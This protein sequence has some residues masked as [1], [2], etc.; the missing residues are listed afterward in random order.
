MSPNTADEKICVYSA[1]ELQQNRVHQG[2]FLDPS[3]IPSITG[4]PLVKSIASCFAA[5]CPG[6]WGVQLIRPERKPTRPTVN[7]SCS[8]CLNTWRDED[9]S[10]REFLPGTRGKADGWMV[11]NIQ[12]KGTFGGYF[13]DVTIIKDREHGRL[14]TV[15]GR[16]SERGLIMV[17]EPQSG[18]NW[19]FMWNFRETTDPEWSNQRPRPLYE[20]TN[21]RSELSGQVNMGKRVSQNDGLQPIWWP[22]WSA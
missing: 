1:K 10:L 5:L 11:E 3:W 22:W 17:E 21:S 9:G 7:K 15:F 14:Q 16:E 19:L 20:L 4:L 18:L 8:L 13:I 12:S 2:P 6:S